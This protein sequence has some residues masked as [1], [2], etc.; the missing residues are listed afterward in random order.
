M[1]PWTFNAKFLYGTQ[2]LFRSLMFAAGEDGNLKL[3]TRDLAPSQHQL[4]YGKAL[5]YSA[6]PST[7]STS[8]GAY[9]G[10][11]PCVGPYY[12]SSTTSQG[13]PIG[14]LSSSLR[15]EHR[16]PHLWKRPLIEIPLKTTL[17]LGAMPAETLSSRLTLS[18]WWVPLGSLLTTAPADSQPSGDLKRSKPRHQ[19]IDLFRI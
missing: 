2:F 8:R 7:S 13:Q 5:Y 14:H 6:D 17:R 11:N 10:L 9:L 4:V 3:L 19:A 1:A 12:L 16:A 18:A 15:L